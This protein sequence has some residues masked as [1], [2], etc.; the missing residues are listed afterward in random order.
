MDTDVKGKG[1]YVFVIYYWGSPVQSHVR[2]RPPQI[3]SRFERTHGGPPTLYF[4]RAPPGSPLN[5]IMSL[6][7]YEIL[8]GRGEWWVE[9]FYLFRGGL[10]LPPVF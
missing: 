5:H 3:N 7:K 1:S 2:V 9:P 8:R 6:A 4:V 10:N